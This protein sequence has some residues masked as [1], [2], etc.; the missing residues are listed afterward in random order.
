M[1]WLVLILI[2]LDPDPGMKIFIIKNGWGV[3]P[4]FVEGDRGVAGVVA[5]GAGGVGSGW[6][7][8][9][10]VDVVIVEVELATAESEG[11]RPDLVVTGTLGSERL[12][13]LDRPL[14]GIGFGGGGAGAGEEVTGR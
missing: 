13:D 5:A 2:L 12:P 1:V 6:S 7:W 10:T 14:G 11:E 4:E 8:G 9:V 3:V